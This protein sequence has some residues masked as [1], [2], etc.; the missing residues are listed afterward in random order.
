MRVASSILLSILLIAQAALGRAEESEV[1]R[2][3]RATPI[4]GNA[5]VTLT[6]DEYAAAERWP[7]TKVL[8]YKQDENWTFLVIYRSHPATGRTAALFHRVIPVEGW[9]EEF[10]FIM[11][12]V[13]DG[14]WVDERVPEAILELHRGQPLPVALQG[15][16]WLLQRGHLIP[17]NLRP[18]L[19]APRLVLSYT[20]GKSLQTLEVSCLVVKLEALS[21][22]DG[23]VAQVAPSLL[24]RTKQ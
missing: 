3:F 22:A 19:T 24:Q 5:T 14:Y 23:F 8:L 1:V 11:A 12:E 20:S 16:Q 7:V 6:A 18:G 4:F 10:N 13:S 2:L 9:A 17:G 21:P 15:G